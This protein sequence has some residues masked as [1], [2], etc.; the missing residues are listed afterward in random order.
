MKEA[1]DNL[2]DEEHGMA[3]N[4]PIRYSAMMYSTI[5]RRERELA[6]V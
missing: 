2:V 6:S 5:R 4:E 3:A 1:V